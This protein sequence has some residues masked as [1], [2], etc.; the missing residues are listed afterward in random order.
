M[1]VRVL[2]M[3]V[4]V[5]VWVVVSCVVCGL[6]RGVW[7]VLCGVWLCVV[8]CVWLW[9]GTLKT[10]VPVCGVQNVPVCTGNMP[11]RVKHVGVLP[12]HTETF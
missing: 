11:T 6:C 1:V 2:K 8:W 7:C 9:C 12:V 3:R 10:Y 4:R 5:C